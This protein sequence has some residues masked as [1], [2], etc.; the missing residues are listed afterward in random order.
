MPIFS[1]SFFQV[2]AEHFCYKYDTDPTPIS[3][4]DSFAVNFFL[5]PEKRKLPKFSKSL[6]KKT[7]EV[8][9]DAAKVANSTNVRFFSI[10]VF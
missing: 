3:R 9:V 1:K 10:A 7:V 4:Y 8:V 6:F 5:F 2:S